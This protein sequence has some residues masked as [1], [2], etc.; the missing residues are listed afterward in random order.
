MRIIFAGSSDFAEPA[1]RSLLGAGHQVALVITQPDKPAGRGRKLVPTP[2]CHT[3]DERGLQVVATPDVNAAEV[4][5]RIT[6]ADAQVAVVAAFGQKLSPGLLES[7]PGGWINIHASLLP[8]YRGAAPI[9]RAILDQC[10]ETGVTVFRLVQRM[11]AGPILITR[12]TAIKPEETTEELHDRLAA[13]GCDA[14]KAALDL[15][16][17]GIPE[18]TPQ[19][20][21]EAT[22][23]RKLRKEDGRIG[24]TRSAQV[25]AA[26]INGMWSWPG[27]TCQY[28]SAA[29]GKSET[30][31]LARARVAEAPGRPLPPGTLDDRL[32]VATGDGYLELLEIKPQGGRKMPWQDF[33]NGRHAQPTDRF[34]RGLAPSEA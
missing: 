7:V 25:E 12:R 31:T 26:H 18:G 11:D 5:D 4:R 8:A 2:V 23:A 3:A 28:T 1:L 13:I 32:H 29:T 27:A 21:S 17:E 15:Y 34:S 6:A 24:F 14:I 9:H 22:Y 33:V 20:A 30:V 16:A 19:D 10:F